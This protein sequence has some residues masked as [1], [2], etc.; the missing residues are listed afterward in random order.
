VNP[1]D[2]Q[3]AIAHVIDLEVDGLKVFDYAAP[4]ITPP[5]VDVILDTLELEGFDPN[6]T[7]ATFLVT[8]F[9]GSVMDRAGQAQLY[10]YITPGK[11]VLGA[12]QANPSLGGSVYSSKVGTVRVGFRSS[13]DGASK[14]WIATIPV[15]V[16]SLE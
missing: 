5:A 14:Y 7:K 15:E 3:T 6:S 4:Q 16:H 11:G 10:D 9:C 13:D 12:L 2:V 8:V 1:Q